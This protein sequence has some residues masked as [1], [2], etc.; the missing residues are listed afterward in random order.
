VA[1]GG[2]EVANK[3]HGP[4]IITNA[5]DLEVLQLSDALANVNGCK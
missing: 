5:A 1:G 4:E 2:F 3:A